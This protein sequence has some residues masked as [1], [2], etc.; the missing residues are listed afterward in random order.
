MANQFTVQG[1]PV[2]VA[3]DPHPKRVSVWGDPLAYGDIGLTHDNARG[4]IKENKPRSSARA[5]GS[6]PRAPRS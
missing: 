5:S 1:T 2:F 6:S 3:A 4:K